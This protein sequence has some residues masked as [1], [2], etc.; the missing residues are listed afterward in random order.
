MR[1]SYAA[2]VYDLNTRSG[3]YRVAL[4]PQPESE[5]PGFR[6]II[7][8]AVRSDTPGRAIRLTLFERDLR[9]PSPDDRD[10]A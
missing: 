5:I 2:G 1:S 7:V 10:A 3:H 4:V 8:Q 6:A 9:F